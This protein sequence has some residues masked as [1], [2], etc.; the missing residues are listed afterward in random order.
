MRLS[1]HAKEHPLAIWISACALIL[2]SYLLLDPTAGAEAPQLS[3]WPTWG[4]F[5]WGA[6]YALGGLLALIGLV[7]PEP[8][9]EATGMMLMATA[10]ATTLISAIFVFPVPLT[11]LFLTALTGGTFT[12]AV[13]LARRSGEQAESLEEVLAVLD[14]R[15]A[16]KSQSR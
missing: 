16:N 14:R 9:Y 6:S 13:S 11:I 5:L 12:R 3:D 10:Y 8:K 2:G 4:V 15:K 1:R 7:R